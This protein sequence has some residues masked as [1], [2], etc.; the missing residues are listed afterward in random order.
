MK[1]LHLVVATSFLLS[2][3]ASILPAAIT[4]SGDVSPDPT[5]IGPNDAITIGSTALGA[6]TV[7]GGSL[8]EHD[9]ATFGDALTGSGVLVVEG[10]GSTWDA[11]YIYLGYQGTGDLQVLNGGMARHGGLEV[12]AEPSGLGSVLVDGAGSVLEGDAI[13]LGSPG[14]GTISVTNGAQVSTTF[15]SNIGFEQGSAGLA[16]V[17]GVGTRWD[18]GGSLH[19]GAEGTGDLTVS[20]GAVVTSSGG[21][22]AYE[23]TASGTTTITGAGSRW[24]NDRELVVG[25]IGH[26]ALTILDG[27]AVTSGWSYVGNGFQPGGSGSVLV[28]GANSSWTIDDVLIVGASGMGT[29]TIQNGGTVTAGL[30]IFIDTAGLGASIEL[31]GGTLTGGSVLTRPD[32]LL[33]TGQVVTNGWVFTGDHSFAS[34]AELP[35]QMILNDLPGQNVTVDFAWDPSGSFGVDDGRVELTPGAAFTSG[36]GYAGLTAGA[37]GEMVVRGATWDAGITRI[38]EYGR[39][40]LSITEGGSVDSTH[41]QLGFRPNAHGTALVEGAG[42]TWALEGNLQI[43]KGWLR[44]SDGASLSSGSLSVVTAAAVENEVPLAVTGAT[45]ETG[46]F[47]FS[48]I[49]ARMEVTEGGM[50]TSGTTTLGGSREYSTTA[51]VRGTGSEWTINGDL[52]LGRAGQGKV[53]VADGGQLVTQSVFLGSSFSVFGNI[54]DG[55]T[56]SVQGAGS[57]WTANGDVLL[58][59]NRRFGRIEILDGAEAIIDGNLDLTFN[60]SRASL[61]VTLTDVNE[62][63]LTVTGELDIN[64]SRL[65]LDLSPDLVLNDGDVFTLADAGSTSQFFSG[66]SDGRVV[67]RAQGFDLVIDYLFGDVLL[68]VQPTTSPGLPGDYNDDG[69]VDAADY[70][71]WRDSLYMTGTGLAADGN[72]NGYVGINDY[73]IWRWHYGTVASTDGAAAANVPEPSMLP[74][75]LGLLLLVRLRQSFR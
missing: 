36:F 11:G 72:G 16:I 51:V 22:M 15:Q 67:T 73:N 46:N 48:A 21:G 58:T 2:L 56:I 37:E 64:S 9:D 6:V 63:P 61:R 43:R 53:I 1:R 20:G 54:L 28:D 33:G 62:T 57:R 41:A 18:S 12:G 71:V 70:T 49:D 75:V 5:T 59:P 19:V 55:P 40:T 50:L 13:W 8:L 17:D 35:T 7:D 30:Q 26:G 39:G 52:E 23:T 27:G 32:R 69:K 14:S 66:A 4:G 34:A 65:E 47:S 68:K 29:L 25:G 38:G 31:N 3:G 74:L 45:L 24:E 10:A 60:P 44:V 42:S